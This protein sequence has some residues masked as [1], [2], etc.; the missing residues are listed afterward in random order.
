MARLTQNHDEV[1]HLVNISRQ[2]PIGGIARITLL[3]GTIIE[4]VTRRI[5]QGN[6]AGRGGWQYYGELEIETKNNERRVI[7]YLEI[8]SALNIWSDS[9]A[10]EYE[11]LGLITIMK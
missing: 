8:K 9:K 10:T 3:N 4:G 7:D 1:M 2:I 5:S 11:Q 6:N